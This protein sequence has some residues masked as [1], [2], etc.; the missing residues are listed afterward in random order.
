LR[1]GLHGF[2]RRQVFRKK[3]RSGLL[4]EAKTGA[5]ACLHQAAAKPHMMR[6]QHL[7]KEERKE[8][9]AEARK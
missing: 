5:E 1:L 9:E 2:P 8:K 3:L 4:G 7:R 6:G